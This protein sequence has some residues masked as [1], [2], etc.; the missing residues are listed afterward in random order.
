M[1][2]GYQVQLPTKYPQDGRLLIM[3]EPFLCPTYISNIEVVCMPGVK[4]MLTFKH[5]HQHESK[6]RAFRILIVDA[7]PLMRK[8]LRALIEEAEDMVISGEA[9]NASEALDEISLTQPDLMI[10]SLYL[11][12]STG[13]D[14]ATVV[15][16][17]YPKIRVIVV[18]HQDAI[19]YTERV[20]QAGAD[21][22][23]ERSELMDQGL[24]T[25]R[26][27]LIQPHLP[28]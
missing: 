28:E 12:A 16:V 11:G 5:N 1:R 7:H 8:G 26:S 4:A 2:P 19:A 24:R 13:L 6:A 15:R 23:L 20:K 17:L 27:L 14:L 22:Y 21:T 25:I 10:T 9:S 3:L 18:S